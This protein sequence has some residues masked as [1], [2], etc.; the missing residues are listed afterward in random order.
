MINSGLFHLTGLVLLVTLDR[1][2]LTLT[3][4]SYITAIRM[5]TSSTM[6][7]PVLNAKTK[8]R[9]LLKKITG[10]EWD[11][12]KKEKLTSGRKSAYWDTTMRVKKPA[13]N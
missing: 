13:M 1:G 12:V 9:K 7:S 4:T 5:F 2:G 3:S 6:E 11:G 10:W 8:T